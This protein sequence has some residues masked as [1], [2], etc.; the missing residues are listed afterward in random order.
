[1]QANVGIETIGTAEI[2]DKDGNLV[3]RFS[4]DADQI[5]D[6]WRLRWCNTHRGEQCPAGL[7]E[8][9]INAD[10]LSFAINNGYG[11]YDGRII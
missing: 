2:R 9:L 5:Y 7:R 1:M 4:S 10:I 3:V 6:K 8:G 11:G